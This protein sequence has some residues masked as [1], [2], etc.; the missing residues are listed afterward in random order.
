MQAQVEAEVKDTGITYK[1]LIRCMNVA[2]R[3]E[4]GGKGVT[5]VGED[6][7]VLTNTEFKG[8]SHSCG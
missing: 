8:K 2:W 4:S 1:S 3:S 7:V 6:K 5:Q